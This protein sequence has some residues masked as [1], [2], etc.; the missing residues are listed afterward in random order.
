MLIKRLLI[1]RNTIS[2][3]M[4]LS[5]SLCNIQNNNFTANS[6][7]IEAQLSVNKIQFRNKYDQKHPKKTKKVSV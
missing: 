5:S 6:P 2:G 7:K 4:R 3:L 1:Q